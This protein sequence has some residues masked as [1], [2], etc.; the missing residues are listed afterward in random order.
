MKNDIKIQIST[1]T[2]P[3][4]L[5]IKLLK[6]ISQL[7]ESR[8]IVGEFPSKLARIETNPSPTDANILSITLYPSDALLRFVSTFG[9]GD[10]DYCIIEKTTHESPP[11][12]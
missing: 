9:A 7:P 4:E 3:L 5:F 12:N 11:N 10:F 2:K 8:I 6:A 1:D